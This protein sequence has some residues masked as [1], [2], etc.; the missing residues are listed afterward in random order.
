MK[1][2]LNNLNKADKELIAL[3]EKDV[4]KLKKSSKKE[5]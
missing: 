5:P 3:L 2:K 4:E 1:E